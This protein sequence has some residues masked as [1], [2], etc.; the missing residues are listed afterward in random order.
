[1]LDILVV[2]MPGQLDRVRAPAAAVRV[3]AERNTHA[4]PPDTAIPAEWNT[5]LETLAAEL[6]YRT[7]DVA[8]IRKEFSDLVAA[9]AQQI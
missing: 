6:G 5:E 3:F 8:K 4:F 9:I 1:M 7:T 2:N